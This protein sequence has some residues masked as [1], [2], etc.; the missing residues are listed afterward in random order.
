MI[1]IY[2]VSTF[3]HERLN[4]Y[5]DIPDWIIIISLEGKGVFE[6]E[7]FVRG[8]VTC[9]AVRVPIGPSVGPPDSKIGRNANKLKNIEEYKRI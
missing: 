3:I 1:A 9:A 4:Y 7:G 6:E 5:L 8:V 2:T